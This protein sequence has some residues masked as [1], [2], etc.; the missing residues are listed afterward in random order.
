MNCG[1]ITFPNAGPQLLTLHYNA[2]NN[3]AYFEFALVKK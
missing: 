3:L 1:E 2:G